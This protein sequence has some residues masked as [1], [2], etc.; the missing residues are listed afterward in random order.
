MFYLIIFVVFFWVAF[1]AL[2][3]NQPL[4][5]AIA[6]YVIF[7]FIFQIILFYLAIRLTLL[8]NNCIAFLKINN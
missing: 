6:W 4:D 3:F 7:S 5:V 8:L 2:T 1:F